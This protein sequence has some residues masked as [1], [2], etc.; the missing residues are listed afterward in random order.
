MADKG[1]LK[2]FAKLYDSDINV[3]FRQQDCSGQEKF[4]RIYYDLESNGLVEGMTFLEVT[5][6]ADCEPR[7]IIGMIGKITDKGQTWLR[8]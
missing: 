4:M 3:F 8:D 2:A 7:Y 1:T 6:L 5:T